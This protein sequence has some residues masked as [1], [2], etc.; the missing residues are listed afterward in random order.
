M[1]LLAELDGFD[2]RGEVRI[3]AATNRPD[4]L[5]PALLRPGRFDRIIEVP[6]PR[7]SA[8]QEI[9]R[10]HTRNMRLA[11]DVDLTE[12]AR[13]MNGASGADIRA[14]CTEAGMYAIRDQRKA[15]R[16]SDFLRAVQR[17][18]GENLPHGSQQTGEAMFA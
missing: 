5:D 9:F 4:I 18:W 13:R 8:L 14:A 11:D 6:L 16:M 3:L 10:I 12:L 17:V 1:Q 2:P 7:E 15:I